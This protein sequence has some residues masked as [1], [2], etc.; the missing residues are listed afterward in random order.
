M[1]VP[2]IYRDKSN[3][4]LLNKD[5]EMASETEDVKLRILHICHGPVLPDYVSAYSLRCHSLFPGLERKIISVGGAIFRDKTDGVSSQFRSILLTAYAA[6]RGN[7]SFEI[8]LSRGMFLRRKYLNDV[9]SAIKNA[10][11]VVFEGPWQ[12]NLFKKLLNEK[13]V[14][15]DAHNCETQLREGNKYHEYVKLLESSLAMECNLLFSVT[16]Q[17]YENL[18]ILS[19]GGDTKFHLVP[20]L[21]QDK[22]LEWNGQN[23][24]EIC[25]IGSKYGPNVTAL[26]FIL[27]LSN[28]LPEFTFNIIG[29]VTSGIVKRGQKN[30]NFYGVV[31]EQKKNELLRQAMLA[32]NPVNEGSGRNVKMVDYLLHSVPIISTKIGLR[33]FENYEVEKSII[34]A[35]REDFHNRIEYL[36]SHRVFLSSLS[37]NSKDL[38]TEILNKEIAA[39]PTQ[40][41]KDYLRHG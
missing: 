10:D 41:L 14:V 24:K 5:D 35:E 26:N 27:E 40:I 29:S 36:D 22:Q 25:F 37:N 1:P 19:N 3:T 20:H 16:S 12:Y 31:P 18:K 6:M 7:R 4:L 39:T 21:L 33:G 13:I 38:F 30:V 32:L 9:K 11:V 15:Y 23:S 17:D 34:V 8:F 28:E 2:Q